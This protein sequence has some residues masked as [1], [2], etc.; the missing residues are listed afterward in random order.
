M[1]DWP[2]ESKSGVPCV[3]CGRSLFPVPDGAGFTFHC[4]SGHAF[5]TQELLSAQSANAS[6]AMEKL[7]AE[8]EAQGRFLE[9]SAED[10]ERNGYP[11]IAELFR[12]RAHR[13]ERKIERLRAAFRKDDSSQVFAITPDMLHRRPLGRRYDS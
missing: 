1:N 11:G 6:G 10:A 3:L 9:N 7:L 13:L 4:K 2:P 12:R 8:W 5:D